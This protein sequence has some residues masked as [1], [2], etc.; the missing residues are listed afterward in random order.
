V[1]QSS[2]PVCP[3][4]IEEQRVDVKGLVGQRCGNL[5][6]RLAASYRQFIVDVTACADSSL[7]SGVPRIAGQKGASL[8]KQET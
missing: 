2:I 4:N 7:V 3:G 6:R 1:D 5:I 8:I